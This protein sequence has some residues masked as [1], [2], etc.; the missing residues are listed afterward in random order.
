VTGVCGEGINLADLKD[1]FEMAVQEG[2]PA[3]AEAER[4]NLK[5]SMFALPPG[6]LGKFALTEVN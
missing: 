3:I 1:I 5:L 6:L 4:A 2:T